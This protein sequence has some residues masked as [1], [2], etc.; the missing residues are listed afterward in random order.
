MKRIM[1][2]P[3]SVRIC[4]IVSDIFFVIIAMA[5]LITRFSWIALLVLAL[6]AALLCF[7]NIQIFGSSILVSEKGK[8]IAITGIQKHTE[9][10]SDASSI[11]S[12]ETKIMGHTTR[13]IVIEDKKGKEIIQIT[14]LNN[15][16]NGYACE[17]I[18][19][20]LGKLLD[21]PFHATVP[22]HLY[23]IKERWKWKR[24]QK[25]QQK[26]QE[27]QSSAVVEKGQLEG[28]ETRRQNYDEEDDDPNQ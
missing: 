20:Q 6:V 7:Y 12:K 27:K 18:A 3:L 14:T 15:L 10:I 16:N 21:V 9:D 1:L 22:S 8:T 11:F 24:E 19:Q 25:K 2:A 23:D 17:K 13:V 4:C 26:S 28:E 5:W